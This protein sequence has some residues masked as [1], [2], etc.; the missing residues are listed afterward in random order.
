MTP[1]YTTP[2]ELAE[3]V[4]KSI[5]LWKGVAAKAKVVVE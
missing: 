1:A 2:A 4:R 3:K 5:E